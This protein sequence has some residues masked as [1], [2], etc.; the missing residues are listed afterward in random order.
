MRS[1]CAGSDRACTCF[2]SFSR[3]LTRLGRREADPQA[4]AAGRLAQS[5]GDVRLPGP[6]TP[7]QAAVVLLIDP[8]ATRQLQDLR[9]GQL[10]DRTKIERIEILEHRERRVLD[11]GR[12]RVGGAGRQL[13]LGEPEQEL[14]ERQVAGGRVPRQLLELLAHRRQPQLP[15]LGLQQVDRRIGHRITPS[16]E[17]R[18]SHRARRSGPWFGYAGAIAATP[19]CS[20]VRSEGS[21]D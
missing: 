2:C 5:E 4:G 21:S 6:R 13:D 12:D 7:D 20:G 18:A 8:L 16:L 14:G 1:S 17:D 19:W 9:L 15:E 10:R 3:R 11:P